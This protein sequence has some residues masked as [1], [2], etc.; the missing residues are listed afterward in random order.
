MYIL[1]KEEWAAVILLIE[2][3]CCPTQLKESSECAMLKKKKMW[4]KVGSSTNGMTALAF[5][6]VYLFSDICLMFTPVK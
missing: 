6:G 1:P 5:L 4:I 3:A 2:L